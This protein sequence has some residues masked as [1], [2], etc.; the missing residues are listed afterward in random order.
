[1]MLELPRETVEYVPINVLL[2]GVPFGGPVEYAIGK[3]YDRPGTWAATTVVGGEDV[4]LFDGPAIF[5]LHSTGKVKVWVRPTGAGPEV[6]VIEAGEI[7]V[8]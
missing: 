4:F 1:M 6:P 8:T 2:K 5:T 3:T 7:K